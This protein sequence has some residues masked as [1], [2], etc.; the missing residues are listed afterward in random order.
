[1]TKNKW[2]VL[3]LGLLFGASVSIVGCSSGGN[4]DDDN[5]NDDDTVVPNDDTADDDDTVVPPNDDTA[6]DD[7]TEPLPNDDT[8]DDD[9]TTG[10]EEYVVNELNQIDV[11]CEGTGAVELGLPKTLAI[12]DALAGEWLLPEGLGE[13]VKVLVGEGAIPPLLLGMTGYVEGDTTKIN[14][15]GALSV[16][17]ATSPAEVEQDM[18]QATLAIPAPADWTCNP[19]IVLSLEE[20]LIDISGFQLAIQDMQITG[21]ISSDIAT[22]D[23]GTLA[24][25]IDPGPLAEEFGLDICATFPQA[26]DADGM[27][28]VLIVDLAAA[29]I[30]LELVEVAAP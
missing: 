6:D 16:E 27:L 1:M 13:T 9:D 18:E 2:T 14:M 12:M 11:P 21:R 20:F 26:C 24:G 23:R 17:G 5:A 7:D 15:L 4:D 29:V 10:G 3:L 22:M 8:D 25:I 28:T 30:N 19:Y